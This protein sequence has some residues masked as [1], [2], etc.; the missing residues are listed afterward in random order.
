M[1][2]RGC[3]KEPDAQVEALCRLVAEIIRRIVSQGVDKKA[4]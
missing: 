1:K 2:P 4:A 3:A